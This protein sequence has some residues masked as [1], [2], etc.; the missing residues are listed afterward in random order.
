MPGPATNC[1]CTGAR[2]GGRAGTLP[3][4]VGPQPIMAASQSELRVAFEARRSELAFLYSTPAYRP[5]LEL[6]G[7][8]HIGEALGDM[9]RRSDWKNLGEHLSDEVMKTLVPHGVYDEIPDVLDEWYAALCSGI[10]LAV[11]HGDAD[12]DSIS[13]MVARCKKIAPAP[14]TGGPRR[15]QT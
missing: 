2:A 11:P 4:V 10:A 3:V 7:L 13:R 12:D 15:P 1:C 5:Q 8:A 9:A 6:F 14:G